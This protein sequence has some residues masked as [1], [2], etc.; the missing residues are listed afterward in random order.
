MNGY[1]GN[2]Q[3]DANIR[4]PNG[5]MF[6]KASTGTLHMGKI[7]TW[8]SFYTTGVWRRRLASDSFSVWEITAG[9]SGFDKACSLLSYLVLRRET[10][11][12]RNLCR[13]AWRFGSIREMKICYVLAE[14]VREIA[15]FC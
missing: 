12:H 1:E 9:L 3:A 10:D 14:R 4:K 11:S 6:L 13:Q 8:V 15:L 2:I 5:G 7:M